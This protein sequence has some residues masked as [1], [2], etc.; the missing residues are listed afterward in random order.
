[1]FVSPLHGYLV[2]VLLTQMH[3]LISNSVIVVDVFLSFFAE[4]G[5]LTFPEWHLF[6]FLRGRRWFFSV[7]YGPRLRDDPSSSVSVFLQP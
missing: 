2:Q 1:M 7:L 3:V 6:L 5:D 4:L